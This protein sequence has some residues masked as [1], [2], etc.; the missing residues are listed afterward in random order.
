TRPMPDEIKRGYL[1]PYDSWASRI[2]TH[3][4]VLDI[5][6][7]QGRDSDRALADIEARLP[8]LRD[9][10]VRLLWGGQDF[11]FDRHYYERWRKLLPEAAAEYLEAAG[12]YV[13]EDAPE[14]CLAE[15]RRHLGG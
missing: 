4:F 2:A 12:H 7:Q 3:R 5:P 14:R 1:F 9:R 11:C 15:V 8:V 10:P 6:R 13:L